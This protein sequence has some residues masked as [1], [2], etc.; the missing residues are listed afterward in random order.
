MHSLQSSI[1]VITT[2]SR[3]E[4]EALGLSVSSGEWDHSWQLPHKPGWRAP[5]IE[6]YA[7]YEYRKSCRDVWR[8]VEAPGTT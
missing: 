3:F 1:T 7:R 6:E 2:P 8:D 5:H 4:S